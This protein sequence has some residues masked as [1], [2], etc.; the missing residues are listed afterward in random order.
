MGTIPKEVLEV[1]GNARLTH[2]SCPNGCYSLQKHSIKKLN[3]QEH[4]PHAFDL[5]CEGCRR[6]FHI[7]STCDTLRKGTLP[8]RVKKR[9]ETRRKRDFEREEL[10]LASSTQVNCSDDVMD[11]CTSSEVIGISKD[12][13]DLSDKL[14][15]FAISDF[16][17]LS[18]ALLVGKATFNTTSKEMISHVPAS[19]QQFQL[20]MASFINDATWNQQQ[21]FADAT[22]GT[23]GSSCRRARSNKPY[24]ASPL[25]KTHSLMRDFCAES[26]EATCA[27]TPVPSVTMTKTNE[28]CLLPSKLIECVSCVGAIYEDLC[29][30][31]EDNDVEHA[32]S[33]C[34]YE[35]KAIM[36][37]K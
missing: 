17:D 18:A 36:D 24:Q 25:P 5:C 8:N 29:S 1:A 9:A 23:E 22:E 31:D 33:T 10:L 30:N 37:A 15:V 13:Q 16:D 21:Q 35:S 2:L 7:C 27:N 28:A 32:N 19:E 3:T 4:P 6:K 26:N 14:R 34:V 20:K 12:A 11:G